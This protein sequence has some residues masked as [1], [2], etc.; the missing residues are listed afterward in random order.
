[1]EELEVFCTCRQSEFGNMISCDECGKWF[2]Q[3]RINGDSFLWEKD[4]IVSI[5]FDLFWI[6][7]K[8]SS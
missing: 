6:C 1:V 5:S 4:S 3:S 8:G 2:H 7:R